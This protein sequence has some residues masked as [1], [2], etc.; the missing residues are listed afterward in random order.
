LKSIIPKGFEFPKK[1][2]SV[3]VVSPKET[4]STKNDV[5]KPQNP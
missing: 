5:A 2:L 1:D 4:P 3:P